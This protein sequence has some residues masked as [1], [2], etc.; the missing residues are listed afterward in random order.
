MQGVLGA[1]RTLQSVSPPAAR[2]GIPK[3]LTS[4]SSLQLSMRNLA[5]WHSLTLLRP[6]CA[7]CACAY[8]PELC[9]SRT[10]RGPKC[11]IRPRL[12][13]RLFRVHDDVKEKGVVHRVL[14]M[15]PIIAPY[16]VNPREHTTAIFFND[17]DR[18]FESILLGGI[19]N[20][21]V[22]LY[23]LFYSF[24]VCPRAL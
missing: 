14:G 18:G 23:I 9:T 12:L 11:C 3:Q 21:I 20:N 16:L 2:R 4:D 10:Y 22:F 24:V 19:Q 8:S 5:A 6:S 13:R 1:L 17:W 15:P 7:S